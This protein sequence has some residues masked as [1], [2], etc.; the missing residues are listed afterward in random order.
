[1]L[2]NKLSRVI[3]LTLVAAMVAVS[4]MALTPNSASAAVIGK[5]RIYNEDSWACM[6]VHG[7]LGTPSPAIVDQWD[8]LNQTN[9]QF[10]LDDTGSAAVYTIHPKSNPTQCLGISG[11]NTFAD[12]A[13]LKQLTC[14][15]LAPQKFKLT[16]LY[17]ANGGY[18]HYIQSVNSGMCLKIPAFDWDNGTRITQ[19]PCLG[20]E[21]FFW[22]FKNLGPS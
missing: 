22:N 19:S 21:N 13:L 2:K 8:C 4:I 11:P 3:H 1:M 20:Q 6:T 15:G 10:Q 7:P 17:A 16:Y 14:S 5:Y 12:G 18:V 9:Q